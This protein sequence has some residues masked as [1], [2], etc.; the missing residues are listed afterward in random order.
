[1]QDML[2]ITRELWKISQAKFPVRILHL[3]AVVLVDQQKLTFITYQKQRPTK[4]DM[5][6][7]LNIT[8]ELWKIS[9]AKFPVR[10]LHIDADQQKLTF[11][12]YQKQRLTRMDG[13]RESEEPLTSARLYVDD[14]DDYGYDAKPC[15]V[16]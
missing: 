3:D 13:E 15:I 4:T 10:I 2:N 6:D 1:M 9:Q 14:D 11:I 16:D 5:Q 7:M 12:T 8:R